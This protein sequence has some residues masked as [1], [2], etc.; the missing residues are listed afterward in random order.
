MADDAINSIISCD[1]VW[2]PT[3]E[4]AAAVAEA[5]VVGDPAPATDPGPDLSFDAAAVS[6]GGANSLARHSATKRSTNASGA[7]PRFLSPRTAH[8]MNDAIHRS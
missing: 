6:D 8:V 3:P 5:V 2:Y 4:E 1:G 7:R